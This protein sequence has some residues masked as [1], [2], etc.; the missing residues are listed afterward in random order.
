M[1]TFRDFSYLPELTEAIQEMLTPAAGMMIVAGPEIRS[2]STASRAGD[3]AIKPSGRATIFQ[4]LVDEALTKNTHHTCRVIAEHK[5]IL[6]VA[7]HFRPRVETQLVTPPYTYAGR[8]QDAPGAENALVVLDRLEPHNLEAAMHAAASGAW[9]AAQLDTAAWGGRAAQHLLDLGAPEAMLSTIS[10]ILTVQRLP[11]L[12]P[13]CKHA[14]ALEPDQIVRMGG[15]AQYHQAAGCP[16]CKFTGRKADVAVFDI[17]RPGGNSHPLWEQPSQLP[18]QE[19]V[20]ELVRTG[21]LPPDEFL[22]FE[23]NQYRRIYYLYQSSEEALRLH[24]GAYEAKMA[25]I[26]ATNRVLQQRTQS[27]VAL[28]EISQTLMSS[29][30][31]AELAK[32]LCRKTCE[33]CRAERSVLYYL[34][35]DEKGQPREVEILAVGG[36]S[37]K[38]LNRRLSLGELQGNIHAKE[39]VPFHRWPPG[40]P[41]RHRDVEGVD[42][43]SGLFAPLYANQELVGVMIINT[44]RREGFTPGEVALLETCA[45]QAALG[46]QRAGLVDDLQGK[47]AQL[48][49]AQAGLAKKERMEHELALARQVQQRVLPRTFPTLPGYHFAAR[50]EPARQVG[51]DFYD[52][53]ALD[54]AHIG[55]AIADVSDKGMPAAVFMAMARSLLRAEAY[56]QTSPRTVLQRVNTLL[57]ELGDADMFVTLFYG[58]IERETGRLVYARGGHDRPLLLRQGQ[59]TFLGGD[60]TALGVIESSTMR[61]DEA[62]I[63]LQPG[64]KL[65]LYTD[66]LSDLATE[67]GEVLGPAGLAHVL[68]SYSHLPA[69]EM[70]EAV[71][72][73]LLRLQGSGEQYDDMTLMIVGVDQRIRLD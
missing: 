13:A 71:F 24:R 57:H 1:F 9:I 38:W 8:L 68:S 64:D 3:Q 39:P 69:E 2:K 67:A 36:W 31:L 15:E 29:T 49:A 28:Y 5:D 10:W 60:G 55:V 25:E 50:N 63:L 37:E 21:V 65:A 33:L 62:E 58:V 34:H 54:E 27:L 32:H 16:T 44:I 30:S 17:F 4:M 66:G 14:A 47:I 48:E 43:R 26:E 42:L 70:C 41:V 45:N 61:M 12:C 40:I 72:D 53:I 52:V 56:G 51:G 23:S 19:Y 35:R 6:R 59:A 7:R 46:I 11:A 73:H 22:Q 20:R 18:M